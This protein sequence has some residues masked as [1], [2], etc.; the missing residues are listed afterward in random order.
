M[1]VARPR[2]NKKKKNYRTRTQCQYA[3]I[4]CLSILSGENKRIKITTKRSNKLS[5]LTSKMVFIK[6]KY[7]TKRPKNKSKIK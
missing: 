7:E 1:T 5:N 4:L 2:R 6:L 3:N